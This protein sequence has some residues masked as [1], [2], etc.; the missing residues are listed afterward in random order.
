M[1]IDLKNSRKSGE[2]VNMRQA[3]V[4]VEYSEFTESTGILGITGGDQGNH[5]AIREHL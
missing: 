5:K 3:F 2:F 1:R 4:L